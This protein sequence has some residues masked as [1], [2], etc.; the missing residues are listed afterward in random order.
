MIGLDLKEN[1]WKISN[2]DMYIYIYIYI[3]VTIKAKHTLSSPKDKHIYTKLIKLH[4]I[5]F[6]FSGNTTG[7]SK[8]AHKALPLLKFYYGDKYK[9]I[10]DLSFIL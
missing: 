4:M 8:L 9:D 1:R 7:A 2:S 10:I 5:F 6:I 3:I